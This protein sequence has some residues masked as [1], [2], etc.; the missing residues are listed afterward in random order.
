MRGRQKTSASTDLQ[1][2]L[3]RNDVVDETTNES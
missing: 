3:G 2:P 1:Q